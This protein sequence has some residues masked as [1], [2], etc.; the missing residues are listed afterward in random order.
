MPA[1]ALEP[2]KIRNL[3]VYGVIRQSEVDD[4]LIP[5]GAVV[6]ALNVHFD[7]KGAITLRPGMV[8]LG[9]TVSAGYP[10]LGMHNPTSA[11]TSA[12]MF[13]VFSNGTNNV[14][15]RWNGSVWSSSLATDTKNY[16]T[17][18]VEFAGRTIRVNGIEGSIRC[19]NG[20]ADGP[21]Y[22]EYTGNPINPQQLSNNNIKPKYIEV[23]KSRVYVAGDSNYPDR[24][25]YSSVISSAGNITWAPS[26]DFV[27]IN[28]NDGENI[29]ALK[30]YSLELLVFKPNY[31]Y[32]FRTAG[33]DPDPLIK[34]G[35]RSQESIV[36]GKKGIYFHHDTG[37]YRYSGGYPVEISR[38][39][40]DIVQAIP[41]SS[42]ADIAGW[43]DD[44]HIYWSVENLTIEGES[45]KNVVIRYTESSEIWTIYSYAD[46][47]K[48]GADYNSGSTLTRLVGT[49]DGVVATFNSGTSDL[50]E[51][52]KYRVITKWYDFGNIYERKVIQ[53]LVVLCEKA[54][55][56][57]LMY[58]V[59]DETNWND[60]GQLR[61]Y[62][63]NFEPLNIRFHRI[64][65]KL[66]G[67]S[68]VEAFIWQGIEV[69]K[70]INEGVIIEN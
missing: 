21:S 18:F 36:E 26:T 27:D 56:S 29:T 7:R 50:G 32:R 45:W 8:A 15:Y 54:Q 55:A 9:S 14:I 34:I 47:I 37:F 39:I 28:P 16:K 42:F 30:R 10:C 33:V 38:P 17:R 70:G 67:V 40:S 22:W 12:S 58:Q 53:Q 41:L 65:F 43:R 48:W 1:T 2:K 24:L 69:V 66:A 64:R 35:T 23:Y 31:I 11:T 57:M 59:D 4:A 3:G 20:L 68:N 52:I 44:D 25:F 5:E 62:L 49:D 63:N 13:A 6:E 46:G 60:L 51:P 19:W 61:K